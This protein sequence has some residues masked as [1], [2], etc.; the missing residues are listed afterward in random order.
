MDQISN[1]N[2]NRIIPTAY[3]TAYP[4]TFTDIPYSKE[5]FAALQQVRQEEGR[6]I[7]GN[8]LKVP[9]LAPELEARY[10]LINKLLQQFRANQVLELAA[11]LSTHGLVMAGETGN[12]YI[13]LDLPDMITMKHKLLN[14]IATV[15]TNLQLIPG[16]ALRLTDLSKA[17]TVFNLARPLTIINEG[18]LRYLSFPEKSQVANNIHMLLKR[19][20]GMWIT[21]DVTPRK[22]LA[23]QDRVTQPGMNG[24]IIKMTG[25]DYT[26][27]MFDDEAHVT[28]FF[29]E[30]GFTVEMHHFNE[31]QEELTSPIAL[32]I[33]P[34][35]TQSLLG[36][37]TVAVMRI[38]IPMP[39]SPYSKR[40][41][42]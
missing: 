39:S 37:G 41:F 6:S 10:K 27:N 18:L 13:E 20:G 14:R 2:Y 25:K 8:D 35:E 38:A 26:N 29:G 15:P 40:D 23:T 22:F 24:H 21:S 3:L 33:S 19:F 17:I 32:G 1:D 12:K 11:G 42:S 9:R 36:T 7:L 28:R 4:R 34:E 5:I 16:N 31:V 30:H